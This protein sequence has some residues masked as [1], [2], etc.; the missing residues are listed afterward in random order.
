MI[1]HDKTDPPN[2]QILEA[3]HALATLR[4]DFTANNHA[5]IYLYI[6]NEQFLLDLLQPERRGLAYYI[7]ADHRQRPLLQKV[8]ERH[9]ILN[10]RTWAT[11]R[12][13]HSKTIV[14][15]AAGA[16]YLTT[17]NLT[18][19]SW[20]LSTNQCVR[21]QSRTLARALHDYFEQDWASAH[22]LIDARP[23]Q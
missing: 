1:E 5:L 22:S 9:P 14:F 10:I 20:T 21:I 23:A 11:N 8:K 4:H 12:T 3:D 13:M 19:G 6:Y 17:A 2:I 15:P 16:T 18:K 7:L